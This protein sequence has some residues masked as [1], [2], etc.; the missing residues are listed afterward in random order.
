MYVI[1]PSG[2]LLHY[3]FIMTASFVSLPYSIYYFCGS[4]VM[5]QEEENPTII[6]ILGKIKIPKLR[7]HES[8]CDTNASFQYYPHL[9]V[10]N[11]QTTRACKEHHEEG[12]MISEHTWC[13]S[14]E[15]SALEIEIR[16]K[17]DD[18]TMK[19]MLEIFQSFWIQEYDKPVQL[20]AEQGRDGPLG[21]DVRDRSG[22]LCYLMGRQ[23]KMEED[24][25]NEKQQLVYILACDRNKEM[26]GFGMYR[27]VTKEDLSSAEDQDCTLY[28]LNQNPTL[29]YL[30][31]NEANAVFVV[32]QSARNIDV[33]E[34]L[35]KE[36]KRVLDCEELPKVRRKHL[37]MFRRNLWP[38]GKS[39]LWY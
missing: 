20:A 32:Y 31:N 38:V 23:K 7:C 15:N 36:C 28:V 30:F 3:S 17:I 22:I 25:K 14:Y 16:R 6:D 2:S 9:A 39:D 29:G 24:R 37:D 33:S 34:A 26:V 1:E 11:N 35:Q 4:C 5:I 8:G 19:R 13:Q 10:G 12:A 18:K 21:P 27:A